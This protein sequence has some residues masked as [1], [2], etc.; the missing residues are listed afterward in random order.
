ML[1]NLRKVVLFSLALLFSS[2][3]FGQTSVNSSLENQ[4]DQFA[5]VYGTFRFVSLTENMHAWPMSFIESLYPDIEARR[6]D[7]HNVNWEYSNDMIIV[8]YSRDYIN[9]ASFVEKM[10]PYQ[11]NNLKY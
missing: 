9:S 11:P 2:T 10:S 5:H 3:S 6:H 4:S 7:K 8:I 1:K